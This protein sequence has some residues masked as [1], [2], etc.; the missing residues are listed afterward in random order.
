M[1]SQSGEVD[2]NADIVDDTTTT[3]AK[4]VIDETDMHSG[5]SSFAV[6]H[7]GEDEICEKLAKQLSLHDV[8][9]VCYIVMY[10]DAIAIRL[11]FLCPYRICISKHLMF[12]IFQ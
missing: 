2:A 1:P 7:R 12:L 6:I 5:E 8:S 4:V 10:D 3:T 9:D 11:Q